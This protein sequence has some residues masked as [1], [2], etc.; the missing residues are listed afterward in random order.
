M[1]VDK[2]REIDEKHVDELEENENHDQEETGEEVLTDEEETE[3]ERQQDDYY[4]Q[5]LRLQADFNNYKKRTEREKEGL[6]SFGVEK[7]ASGLFPILD[8]FERALE[9]KEDKEDGFYKGVEMIYE[10]FLDLLEKN[11][12]KEINAL[13]EKFDPV[14]HNAVAVGQSEEYEEGTIINVL[15]KG[16]MQNDKVIR[17]AMV[18]VAQ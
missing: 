5:L 2:E 6:V 15:Q 4:N 12:I 11:S 13:Y 18:M 9:S 8:N 7:L 3:E 14:Y 1:E 17:P 10:Q 16:Y